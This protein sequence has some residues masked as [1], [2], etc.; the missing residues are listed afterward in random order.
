M[1][2]QVKKGPLLSDEEF[3]QQ[4]LNE[5]IDAV[6]DMK[7]AAEAGDYASARHQFAE[8]IRT[9]LQPE[10]FFSI[11]YEKPENQ[12]MQDGE[13]AKEAAD[14]ICENKMISCGIV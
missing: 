14:R 12:I 10:I 4:C 5:E 1:M 3:F 8:Y 11:P 9:S 6:K 7:K 13:T 2:E